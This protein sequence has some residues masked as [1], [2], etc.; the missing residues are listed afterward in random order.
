VSTILKNVRDIFYVCIGTIQAFNLLSKE[1]PDVIFLKGGFVG[2]PVGLAAAMHKI[3]FV[4]HDS[5]ALP[6]LTNR[7]VGRWARLHATGLPTEFYSY[8]KEKSRY[9]GVL[10]G[11]DFVPVTSQLQQQYRAA[12]QL[13]SEGR[14]LLVTGGSLGARRLNDEIKEIVPGLLEKYPD[15][16]VVHQ[17][18]K[19]N[20]ALYKDA[21]L[22]P[23]LVSLEFMEGMYRYTGAADVVITRAGANTLAEL[24]VQGKA[25]VVVPNP[26]LTGGHQLEN[27]EYLLQHNAVLAVDEESFEKGSNDLKKAVEKLLD[28]PEIRANLGKAL[29]TITKA[30]A[31]QELASLLLQIGKP[32]VRA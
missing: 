12:L 11:E 16:F 17:V 1:R 24:G 5:D 27:A 31:A 7:L 9:V 22:P 19:G 2:L 10:V 26:L 15:L 30:N 4:T 21:V 23:R 20:I 6:G 29:Q 14:L 13:P 32:D 18:G 28:Y 25:C 3:P 8:A